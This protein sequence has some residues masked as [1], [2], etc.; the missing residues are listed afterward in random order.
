MRLFTKHKNAFWLSLVCG[1]TLACSPVLAQG[2]QQDAPPPPPN[3]QQPGARPISPLAPLPR[4]GLDEWAEQRTVSGPYRLTYTLTEMDGTKRVGSQHYAIM[5]DA[6]ASPTNLRLGTKIPIETG[7]SGANALPSQTQI[8]YIDVGTNI[9]SKLRQ[10]ANGL[11]LS[12]HVV[13]SAVDSPQSLLKTPVI[14]QTD[15]QSTVL[16]N[17]DKPIVLGNADTPGST[18]SLQIQVELTKV[19]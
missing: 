9:Q 18:H 15:L 2:A 3:G 17:E 16:L 14:R 10:F 6:D 12:S 5:L 13:Q 4:L 8:S 19:P 7:A 11:E 1:I